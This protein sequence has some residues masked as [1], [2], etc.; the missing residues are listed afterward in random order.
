MI[1]A[2]GSH[3]ST[4]RLGRRRLDEAGKVVK[5]VTVGSEGATQCPHGA[6][7]LAVDIGPQ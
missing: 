1:V 4:A 7:R 5:V 2:P 3:A 6:Q